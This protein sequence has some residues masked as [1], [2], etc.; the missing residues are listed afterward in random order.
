MNQFWLFFFE[1]TLV[2]CGFFLLFLQN[3]AFHKLFNVFMWNYKWLFMIAKVNIFVNPFCSPNIRHLWI[4]LFFLWWD[5]AEG[6]F[7][8]LAFSMNEALI[9]HI[10]FSYS[11][12]SPF[13]LINFLFCLHF[14]SLLH[15]TNSLLSY[16]VIKLFWSSEYSSVVEYLPSIHKVLGLILA[17]PKKE[18]FSPCIFFWI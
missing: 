15:L 17:S 6:L 11:S 16:L 10:C 4:A 2:T 5:S 18:Y 12:T 8:L 3:H 14:F 7:C 1:S 13:I 9:Y